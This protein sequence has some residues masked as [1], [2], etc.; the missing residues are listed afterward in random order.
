MKNSIL[1]SAT[2]RFVFVATLLATFTMSATAQGGGLAIPKIMPKLDELKYLVAKGVILYPSCFSSP[3]TDM[4]KYW[5]YLKTASPANGP[6][7][8]VIVDATAVEIIPAGNNKVISS[9]QY[10]FLDS[11]VS[12]TTFTWV[13]SGN[14]VTLNTTTAILKIDGVSYPLQ[15]I[16]ENVFSGS[17]VSGAN[18]K[19]VSCTIKRGTFAIEAGVFAIE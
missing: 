17:V 2:R 16:A 11:N 12:C 14:T 18:V 15:R 1:Y 19:V 8:A 13:S 7:H 3:S 4:R 9:Q 6:Y 5:D 10:V